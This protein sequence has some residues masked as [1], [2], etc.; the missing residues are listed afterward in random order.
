MTAE[1]NG[2]NTSQAVTEVDSTRRHYSQAESPQGTRVQTFSSY[3]E[4]S[5][6]I[7]LLYALVVVAFP[8]NSFRARYHEKYLN[9]STTIDNVFQI[10]AIRA[11]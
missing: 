6:G 3:L 7:E 4:F 2:E 11:S 9:I 1:S 5:T 10:I 8:G